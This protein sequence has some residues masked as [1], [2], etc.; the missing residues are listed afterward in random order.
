MYKVKR[1]VIM[2]AGLGSRMR[3]LTNDRPK[4]MIKVNGE[5]MIEGMIRRLIE[6]GIEEIYIV[7]GHKKECFKEITDRY[8]SVQLIDNP[9]YKD[10][11]NISSIYVARDHLEECM[12]LEGDQYITSSRPLTADFE[13]TEYNAYWLDEPTNE[14]L[15]WTDDSGKIIKCSDKGGEKGWLFYG[16]SR[17]T[18]EDGRRL[19]KYIEYEFEVVKKRDCYWDYVPIYFHPEFDIYIREMD[20][21]DRIELDSVEELAKVDPSYSYLLG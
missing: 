5:M 12:I 20:R 14:W 18:K 6:N 13:H 7:V 2:A 15:C 10:T 1:A 21:N 4:P 17:W 3:E 16:I 11:N 9:Y 8:P 19:K